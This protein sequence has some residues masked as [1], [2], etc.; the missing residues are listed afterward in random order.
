MK[1]NKVKSEASAL[2]EDVLGTQVKPTEI[3]VEV[4]DAETAQE[5]TDALNKEVNKRIK[6]A[7][8][9][10]LEVKGED[11]VV[12]PKLVK[13]SKDFKK[14]ERK[15][16]GAF[17]KQLKENKI[18]HIVKRSV[19]EGFRYT[20]EYLNP[21]EEGA[22]GKK[23][24]GVEFVV[25]D[26]STEGKAPI[27]G[28]R[29]TRV[30][31][32]WLMNRLMK[33]GKYENVSFDEAP[34]GRFHK[35]DDFWG[36]FDDNWEKMES[37]KEAVKQDDGTCPHCHSS[38][39][40]FVDSDEDSTKYICR[41]CG[42]DF[43]VLD[44][45]SVTTR[46]GRPIEES[47]LTEVGPDGA[48]TEDPAVLKPEQKEEPDAEDEGETKVVIA[49]EEPVEEAVE[50][51]PVYAHNGSRC[52]KER[53]VSETKV[54][55]ECGKE[56]C[57][58]DKSLK[59]EI[60]TSKEVW[61]G[62][63]VQDF[64]DELEPSFEQIM[65]G[66]AWVK[67]FASKDE[68]KK[69]CMSEQPY[70]KKYI[71]EV[72]AYFDSRMKEFGG[73]GKE[74]STG[75]FD[76]LK[77]EPK[78]EGIISGAEELSHDELAKLEKSLWDKLNAQEVYPDDGTFSNSSNRL[79]DLDLYMVIDGDWKHDHLFAEHLVE[80]WCK[81]NGYVIIK[82]TETEIGNSNSDWYEAEHYWALVKDT[83]GKM[84]DTVD[85]LKKMF[86]PKDESLKESFEEIYIKYWKDEELRDQG[87]S[88]IYRDNFAT[89]EEAIEVARKLV[90]RD[91]MASVEVFVSP[92]GELESEDDQLIWG[93]DGI[94]TWGLGKDKEKE[95]GLEKAIKIADD[96]I[97]D[98]EFGKDTPERKLA[99]VIKNSKKESLE[100]EDDVSWVKSYDMSALKETKEIETETVTTKTDKTVNETLDDE[101]DIGWFKGE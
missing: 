84:S 87:I 93:Y 9:K 51:K 29:S 50:D 86:A 43:I 34:K 49:K 36:P 37:I 52:N 2:L 14:E 82:H 44:D 101:D 48:V 57:E 75:L 72:V 58:C 85:G 62:W 83:N 4:V 27:L 64:I 12:E 25:F 56:V 81:E 71:P 70:Y 96:D 88:E 8:K 100:D 66:G 78:Q 53:K 1:L 45:G 32:E 31:A 60:D 30:E 61:E 76:S 18:K 7:E 97:L 74:A 89:R 98:K 22:Q 55:P 77:K 6:E 21:V 23:E 10:A 95:L 90:D 3:K 63:T 5:H 16:L 65:S 39:I 67:P 46:N 94:D 69:W 47:K 24:P 11:H 17:I 59:E 91:G 79:A 42:E 68:L 99:G 19:N 54:C 35:G 33:T 41:D 40:D 13:E 80:E 38:N 92:S 26:A 28:I 73:Y 20:V 15:A